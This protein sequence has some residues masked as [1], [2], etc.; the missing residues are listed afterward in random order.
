M[1]VNAQHYHSCRAPFYKPAQLNNEYSK[2]S[3]K[4]PRRVNRYHSL[5][6]LYMLAR[7]LSSL[8]SSLLLLLMFYTDFSD[9]I[10]V[11]DYTMSDRVN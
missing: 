5:I 8:L 9:A 11:T 7:S 10:T 2:L 3:R 6:S 4:K 1:T